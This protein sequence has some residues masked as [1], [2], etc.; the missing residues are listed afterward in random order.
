MRLFDFLYTGAFYLLPLVLIVVLISYIFTSKEKRTRGL[1][2]TLIVVSVLQVCVFIYW[3]NSFMNYFK[4][5]T[6]DDLSDAEIV[7]IAEDYYLIPEL[8]PYIENV[9]CRGFRDYDFIYE[10]TWFES[11]DKLF[12]TLP[13][14]TEGKRQVALDLLDSRERSTIEIPDDYFGDEVELYQIDEIELSI[15]MPEQ[16]CTDRKCDYF[17]Y[18]VAIRSDN[19][20]ASLI[21]FR[22]QI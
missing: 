9:S 5:Q 4:W 11:A 17:Y 3:I 22:R 8:A 18:F 2:I 20:Q 7:S 13:Y 6:E 14:E 10:T 19:G 12:E 15:T 1:K 21:L 16:V